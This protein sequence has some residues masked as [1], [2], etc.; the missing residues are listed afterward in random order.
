VNVYRNPRYELRIAQLE[1]NQVELAQLIAA[2]ACALRALA[3]R[4]ASSTDVEAHI[5]PLRELPRGF[6]KGN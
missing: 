5:P 3:L 1:A 2:Q 4:V 6:G